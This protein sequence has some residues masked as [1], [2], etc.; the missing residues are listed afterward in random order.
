[1]HLTLVPVVAG[2]EIK[3]KPTQHSVKE[4]RGIGI[5]PDV[6]LCRCR[7]PLPDEQRRKI[8]LFTN[9]EERAVFSAVDAD[10][11]YK[12]PML[13]HEQGLDEIVCDKLR[14]TCRR[15]TCPSGATW[16]RRS[17]TRRRPSTSRW[18][19]STCRSATRTSR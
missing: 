12:I 3:T 5:Q 17:R 19:A 10:D 18:S 13:L 6:L 11:I 8:A 1:M 9:V 2:G 16:S 14:L 7:D 4:L 15:R